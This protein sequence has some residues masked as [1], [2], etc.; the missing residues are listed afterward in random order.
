MVLRGSETRPD[1]SVVDIGA[2]LAKAKGQLQYTEATF[3]V[4]EEN[5]GV[6]SGDVERAAQLLGRYHF[7]SG[8]VVRG[9]GRGRT[10]GF[11]TANVQP[12]TELLP[13]SG[14]YAVELEVDGARLSGVANLGFR[15]TFAEKELSLEVHAFDTVQ[16]LYGKRVLV[17]FVKRLREE[18]RFASADE[19][20]AQI[21]KDAAQA[22]SLLPAPP[23]T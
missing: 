9:R 20:V 10:I 12:R 22:R 6:V 5:E 18:R 17:S 7:V 16:D 11:P 2:E 21:R 8:V 14:V 4:V 13:P 19:L 3:R 23:V 1:A 15:P